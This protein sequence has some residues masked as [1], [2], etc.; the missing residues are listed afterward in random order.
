MASNND[1]AEKAASSLGLSFDKKRA[2]GYGQYGGYTMLIKPCAANSRE[3]SISLLMCVQKNGAAADQ[4]LI[5][6]TALP[7]DVKFTA[8]NFL[9]IFDAKVTFKADTVIERLVQTAERTASAL[10]S[11]GYTNC[12]IEGIEGDTDVYLYKNNYVFLN[13]SD[14][15]KIESEL[16]SAKR[17][18]DETPENRVMGIIGGLLGSLAGVLVILLIGRLRR[19]SVL[20]GL[21]MGFVSVFGYKKLGHKLSS[22]GAVICTVIAVAMSYLAFRIDAALDLVNLCKDIEGAE[23]ITFGFC[24]LYAKT[25][26]EIGDALSTYYTNMFLIMLSGAGGA[27]ATIWGDRATTKNSFKLEKIGG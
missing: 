12:N 27:A 2:V 26:F 4:S 8:S 3:N 9:L 13:S 24:F 5:D 19:V 16:S 21:V 22:A 25:L 6:P 18:Y 20:G 17:E 23:D 7:K 14:A 1:I 15:D 10:A 11:A